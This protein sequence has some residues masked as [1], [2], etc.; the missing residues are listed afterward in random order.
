MRGWHMGQQLRKE[1]EARTAVWVRIR[2]TENLASGS[3][4][5][6][7][8]WHKRQ[9]AGRSA[10]VCAPGRDDDS[11]AIRSHL[12]PSC[13]SWKQGKTRTCLH[14]FWSFMLLTLQ[15]LSC[16]LAFNRN[17][18]GSSTDLLDLFF[19]KIGFLPEWIYL[20]CEKT[21]NTLRQ[22]SVH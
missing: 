1:M 11:W 14:C 16:I 9:T 10:Q 7:W 2:I 15:W 6:T 19:M 8:L 21:S 5:C 13:P 12:T 18:F 22:K 3:R 20:T 17:A 4:V